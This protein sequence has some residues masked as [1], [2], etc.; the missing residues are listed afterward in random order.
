MSEKLFLNTIRYLNDLF[1]ENRLTPDQITR[2]AEFAAGIES[3]VKAPKPAQL[4]KSDETIRI[5]HEIFPETGYSPRPR[6]L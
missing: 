2:L 3:P 4:E 5:L 6:E 1:L